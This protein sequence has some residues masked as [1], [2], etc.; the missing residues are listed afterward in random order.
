MSSDTA[1]SPA[2]PLVGIVAGE[3]SGDALAAALIRAVRERH[4]Q[5]RF[6]GIAGPKMQA[7]GC[8]AWVA[9]EKLAVRG[10][11]EV[12]A[13]LPELFR[14]RGELR[15]RLLAERAPLFV[16]AGG[17]GGSRLAGI[18]CAGGPSNSGG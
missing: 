2:R 14:I 11:T 10:F 16:G 5:V 4:P 3:T 18:G 9:M 13:H 8:E 15:A 7:E 17:R 1:P 6:A 12:V